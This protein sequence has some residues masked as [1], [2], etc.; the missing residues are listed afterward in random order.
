MAAHWSE[1]YVGQPYVP[2]ENDCAELAARVQREVF[3]REIRLP[4]ERACGLRGL[5]AQI[6]AARDDYGAPTDAPEDG[7]AVLM[8]GRGRLSHVGVYCLIED[9][10]WVLHAMKRAGQ[11]VRHRLREL[12]AQGLTVEGFYKWL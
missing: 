3:G 5:S 2:G 10:P 1:R 6:G 4:S 9:V 8:T 7:D 11:V 12:P